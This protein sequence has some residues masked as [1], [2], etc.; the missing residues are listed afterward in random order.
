MEVKKTYWCSKKKSASIVVK[1][2]KSITVWPMTSVMY[3]TVELSDKDAIDLADSIK[4][5]LLSKLLTGEDDDH[6]T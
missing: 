5:H 1:F 2:D 4:E 3:E 6:R